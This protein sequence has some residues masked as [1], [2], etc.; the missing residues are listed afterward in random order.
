MRSPWVQASPETYFLMRSS[1]HNILAL[2]SL[3][4]ASAA[5]L[6]SIELSK[7][8]GMHRAS[9][10]RNLESLTKEG[11]LEASGSPRR[12]AVS[13]S[14]R[15]LGLMATQHDRTHEVLMIY[16][17][18][19]C[20][21]LRAP[22][23]VG[24]YEDGTY[25]ASVS[26]QMIDGAPVAVPLGRRVFATVASGGLIML[27]YQD[28]AEIVRVANLCIPRYTELTVT[29]P[30]EI[31]EIVHTARANG[32]AFNYGV[33]NPHAGSFAVPVFSAEGNLASLGANC[34][35]RGPTEEALSIAKDL[36]QRASRE[37]GY[38]AGM[39]F[40]IG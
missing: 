13:W 30:A 28:E 39:R 35:E 40:S 24:Y 2:L 9:V 37:L 7:Q 18:Q 27:A 32:Y 4:A 29:D 8:T 36:A 5:P 23:Y 21:R 33:V 11:W 1:R 3:L 26:V 31:I 6:T 19:L 22:S 12:Y 20:E 15:Q 38:R 16:A 17:T 25:I 34:D 10:Y 14:F